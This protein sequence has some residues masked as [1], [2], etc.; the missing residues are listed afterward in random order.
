MAHRVLFI[1][2]AGSGM[3]QMTARQALDDGWMVAG[4][5]LRG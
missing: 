5:E 3:G 2:G 4:G 1:T